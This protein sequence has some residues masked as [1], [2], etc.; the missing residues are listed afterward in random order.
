MNSSRFSS[1]SP[2]AATAEKSW[3]SRFA[4]GLLQAIGWL[5]LCLCGALVALSYYG[6]TLYCENFGCIAL[7]LVWMIWAATAGVGLVV[8]L[9]VRSAQRRRGFS[10]RASGLAVVLLLLMGAGH[11]IYW[12]SV[13][14]LK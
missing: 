1:S 2:S 5:L 13:T 8:A 11:L 4:T 7:G 10:T 9:V 14:T 12:L 3:W 6:F